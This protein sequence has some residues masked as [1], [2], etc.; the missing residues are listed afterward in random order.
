VKPIFHETVSDSISFFSSWSDNA[1]TMEQ[2]YKELDIIERKVK[3]ISKNFEAT[4]AIH[5]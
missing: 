5:E 3:T 2:F 4:N 1:S